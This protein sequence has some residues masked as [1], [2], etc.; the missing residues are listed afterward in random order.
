MKLPTN[1]LLLALRSPT[2]GWL[3]TL[4][5]AL[6]EA[7]R[8]PDFSEH[9]RALARQLLEASAI[10]ASVSTAAEERLSHFERAV[11]ETQDNLLAAIVQPA[12]TQPSQPAVTARPKLTLVVNSVAA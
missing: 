3:A 10:P 11:A 6:D 9:H 2:S 5:C 8:D 1:E 4:V 12:R 7:V